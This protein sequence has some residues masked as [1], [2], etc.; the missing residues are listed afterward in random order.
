ML[1]ASLNK[2]HF[3]SFPS[4]RTWRARGVHHG[5]EVLERVGHAGL[6]D[7]RAVVL[8]DHPLAARHHGLEVSKHNST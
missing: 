1:S 5:L 7:V 8:H 6:V 4:S 3:F 2:T